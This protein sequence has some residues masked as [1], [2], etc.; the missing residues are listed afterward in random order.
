MYYHDLV[1]TTQLVLYREVSFKRGYTVVGFFIL[2]FSN[3][4]HLVLF[5]VFGILTSICELHDL[6]ASIKPTI[7]YNSSHA[8]RLTCLYCVT[9]E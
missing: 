6:S 8:M 1:G 7:Q 5:F 3:A 9:I 2:Y 4:I